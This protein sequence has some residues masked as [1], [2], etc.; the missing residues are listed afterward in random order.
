M[1]H[2][3]Q[4]TCVCETSEAPRTM[5]EMAAA[6]RAAHESSGVMDSGAEIA[7][8]LLCVREK[9]KTER[10]ETLA[11]ERYTA[12]VMMRSDIEKKLCQVSDAT[13]WGLLCIAGNQQ[14]DLEVETARHN[15]ALE[16]ECSG[17]QGAV[18]GEREEGDV[19]S[20]QDNPKAPRETIYIRRIDNRQP[21][22]T[23]YLCSRPDPKSAHLTNVRCAAGV[24]WALNIDEARGMTM[25]KGA[26]I[27]PAADGWTVISIGVGG[28][29]AS[30]CEEIARMVGEGDE[31][32]MPAP[33]SASESAALLP[34]GATTTRETV[35]LRARQLLSAATRG[36][37]FLKDGQVRHNGVSRGYLDSLTGNE[38]NNNAFLSNVHELLIQLIDLDS[39]SCRQI[40]GLV[41]KLAETE[42]KLKIANGAF[43]TTHDKAGQHQV[44]ISHLGQYLDAERKRA[45]AAEDRLARAEAALAKV[46]AVRARWIEMFPEGRS[47][48]WPWR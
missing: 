15:A 1:K 26:E 40:A 20:E 28:L 19:V 35:I 22:V 48:N 39:H 25:R 16:A 8:Q 45:A 12:T 38:E 11:L 23:S 37:W 17:E 30:E 3:C 36:P 41:E 9:L 4:E 5:L 47:E 34:S 14:R 24:S 29:S 6:A 10:A 44:E 27:W 7:E 31:V 43:Q 2:S 42:E 18:A 21:F 33:G 32:D 13:V 46:R